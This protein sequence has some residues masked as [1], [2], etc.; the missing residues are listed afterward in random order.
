MA[1]ITTVGDRVMLKKGKLVG[2]CRFIGEVKGKSGVFYG[3]ELD[4]AKGKNDGSAGS[5]PYFKCAKKH[6]LFVRVSGIEKTNTKQNRSAPRVTVGDSIQC[7]KQKCKGTIRFIGTPYSVKA[8]GVYYGVEL[9]RPKGKNNGTVKGRWYFDCKKQYGSFL[10]PAGFTLLSAN[11]N[12]KI[13]KKKDGKKKKKK[14]AASSVDIEDDEKVKEEVVPSTESQNRNEDG[15]EPADGAPSRGHDQ[16]KTLRE[17]FKAMDSDGN[18]SIERPE[19]QSMA[20]RVFGC[21]VSESDALFVEIDVN[22]SGSISFAEF[23]GWIQSIGGIEHVDVRVAALRVNAKENEPEH[24]PASPS[25]PAKP[26]DDVKTDDVEPVSAPTVSVVEAAEIED[27]PEPEHHPDPEPLPMEPDD[28]ANMAATDASPGTEDTERTEAVSATT[29]AAL[30]AGTVATEQNE[31]T[32]PMGDDRSEISVDLSVDDG[33]VNEM[34]GVDDHHSD[35][36]HSDETKEEV[37]PK[38][39]VANDDDGLDAVHGDHGD[40]HGDEAPKVDDDAK[41]EAADASASTSVEH[42]VES[43]NVIEKETE[44]TMNAPDSSTE[45]PESM[46]NGNGNNEDGDDESASPDQETMVPDHGQDDDR[47]GQDADDV[48]SEEQKIEADDPG[49]DGKSASKEMESVQDVI[50]PDDNDAVESLPRANDSDQNEASDSGMD[51]K[52]E[53]NEQAEV[54]EVDGAAPKTLHDAPAAEAN[55]RSIADEDP[56]DDHAKETEDSGGHNSAEEPTT[57][58]AKDEHDANVDE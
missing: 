25:I 8:K 3:I 12:G 52:E 24:E 20:S 41:E 35:D 19:F 55:I 36:D 57:S 51:S 18:M 30:T 34:D 54:E 58:P 15:E 27:D 47:D 42:E 13:S 49:D 32:V 38:E 14:R 7:T 11:G 48:K 40:E 16:Y 44:T 53:T 28:D 37:V 26:D 2:V 46:V 17:A 43:V 45:M 6:G 56:V 50:A 10:Q 29:V 31:L 1:K 23:D 39:D 21:S 22:H 5:V 9:E 4:D 33:V